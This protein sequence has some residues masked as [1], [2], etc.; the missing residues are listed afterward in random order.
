MGIINTLLFIAW[1]AFVFFIWKNRQ[2]PIQKWLLLFPLSKFLSQ[3]VF[4]L[5]LSQ[6]PWVEETPMYYFAM[7]T[8]QI[9]GMLVDVLATTLINCL[10]Y[11]MSYGWNITFFNIR[12]EMIT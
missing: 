2:F 4:V 1:I 3:T 10:F 6:C 8:W 9:V 12:R 7:I 5:Y 11:L